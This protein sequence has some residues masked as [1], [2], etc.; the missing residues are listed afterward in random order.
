M[1]CR[2]C[3][4]CTVCLAWPGGQCAR[5]V[6]PRWGTTCSSAQVSEP[7]CPG[8]KGGELCLG[9]CRLACISPGL[10]MWSATCCFPG[11]HLSSL[12]SS[13]NSAKA[14]EM[15]YAEDCQWLGGLGGGCPGGLISR[16]EGASSEEQPVHGPWPARVGGSQ[17]SC[18]LVMLL[19]RS[20]EHLLRALGVSEKYTCVLS[21]I[22]C[23][24][25][26]TGLA[27]FCLI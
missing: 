27:D 4:A 1:L 23:W 11:A 9:S 22:C 13:R 21:P 12:S 24:L 8:T 26:C 17:G 3:W 16:G 7:W 18:V 10:S 15:E 6:G 14:L 20:L 5:P 19:N 2:A 25:M